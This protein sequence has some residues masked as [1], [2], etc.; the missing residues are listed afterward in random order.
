MNWTAAAEIARS[1]LHVRRSNWPAARWIIYQRGIAWHWDGTVWRVVT[2][3]DFSRLEW[4]ANDWT[5]IPRAL[6]DC[7]PPPGET[8]GGAGSPPPGETG[9]GGAGSAF[10]CVIPKMVVGVRIFCLDD[11]PPVMRVLIS[12]T[13]TGGNGAWDVKCAVGDRVVS[14]GMFDG[15]SGSKAVDTAFDCT[16]GA[17]QIFR[18]SARGW[19]N[20][21]PHVIYDEVVL[22]CACDASSYPPPVVVPVTP[23]VEPPVVPPVEPPG[24]CVT[25]GLAVTAIIYCPDADNPSEKRVVLGATLSG[26]DGSWSVTCRIGGRLVSLGMLSGDGGSGSADAFVNCSDGGAQTFYFTAT[27]FGDCSP[28]VIDATATDAC[29]CLF[30]GACCM[31]SAAGLVDGSL[32]A[33]DLPDAIT[34]LGV[35]SLSRSGTGYGNTTNGVIFETPLWAKY[36][37]GVRTTQACLITGDGY[38]AVLDQFA[39]TYNVT[40]PEGTYVVTRSGLCTWHWGLTAQALAA[41]DVDDVCGVTLFWTGIDWSVDIMLISGDEGLIES[42]GSRCIGLGELGLKSWPQNTPLGAY[43][44]QRGAPGTYTISV[45]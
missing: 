39:A 41:A 34:L 19:W 11:N 37:G 1:G 29:A 13:M 42:L 44:N 33:A 30:A 7:P 12:A 10:D 31:Y 8:G 23:P 18:F 38:N 21:S 24:E 26:G 16:E 22:V 36:V 32:V 5:T 6:E 17:E 27:G 14:L 45:A 2:D 28:T 40:L 3:A 43:P 9:G 25:P 15:G 20:C 4:L 35:G